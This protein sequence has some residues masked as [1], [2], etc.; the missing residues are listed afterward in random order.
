MTRMIFSDEP[1][2]PL[3]TGPAVEPWHILVV[4]DEPSVHDVTRL[5]LNRLELFGHKI[6]LHSAFSAADARTLMGSDTLFCVAFIDVV[7]ET[8]HAGL[9][10]VEWIRNDR[11]NGAIRLILRTGQAGTAPESEV[12]RNYDINDYKSKTELTAQGLATCVFNA[13]RG[14]KDITTI[15]NQLMAFRQL[16]DT[17]ANLLKVDDLDEMANSALQGLLSILRLDSSALYLARRQASLFVEPIDTVLS[18]ANASNQRVSTGLTALPE[19]I[20]ARI[21]QAFSEKSSLAGKNDFIG[22]FVTG[23]DAAVV[24]LVEYPSDDSH[25]RAGLIEL[26]ASQLVLIFENLMRQDQLATNQKELMYIVGDA[27][28]ARSLETGSHVKRVALICEFFAERLKMPKEFIEAIKIAAPLHDIGKIAIPETILHKP[29]KFTPEEWAVMQTH[30]AAGAQILEKSNLPVAHLGARLAR[31]HHENWDGS[32][33]PDGLI[34]TAIPME[35]RI[36][37]IADVFDALGSRR[38][39]KEP[40]HNDAIMAFIVDQSG[41]KFDPDLVDVLRRDID[42]LVALRNQIPD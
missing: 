6:E 38:S 29:G 35:A 14:Y 20:R 17:S 4:D 11:K 40:W 8:P 30:S 18:C 16:I 9:E 12:I 2:P 34:G 31:W 19:P 26:Y 15:G 3:S 32:G 36:M 5:T 7:M 10:L 1:I 28:E 24:L 42:E 27:I 25:F 21:E 39:Y 37:A 41:V 13:V 23:H 33:Y 22:Y